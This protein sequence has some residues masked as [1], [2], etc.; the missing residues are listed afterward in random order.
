MNGTIFDLMKNEVSAI[1]TE[2]YP[3]AIVLSQVHDHEVMKNVDLS[4]II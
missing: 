3:M 4:D 2:G 1:I